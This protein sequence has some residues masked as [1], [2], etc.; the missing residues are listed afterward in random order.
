MPEPN[1][2][3]VNP[4]YLERVIDLTEVKDVEAAED[5]YSANGLKLVAKGTRMSAAMQE[6]LIVHKLKKPLEKCIKVV[7]GVD[8]DRIRSAVELV[9]DET[10]AIRTLIGPTGTPQQ[11]LTGTPL[12]DSVQLM[13]TLVDQTDQLSLQHYLKVSLI[14]YGLARQIGGDAVLQEIALT[15]GLMHDIGELYINPDYLQKNRLLRPVEWR[16][17]VAHP[18]IAQ[19]LLVDVSGMAPSV[20]RAVAEH[21]ERCDGLGYPKQLSA[22]AISP[23][24]KLLAVAEIL[25]GIFNKQGCLLQRAEI[26]LKIVPGEHPAEVVAAISRCRREVAQEPPTDQH[27]FE[28]GVAEVHDTLLRIVMAQQHIET[29]QDS[30]QTPPLLKTY[31]DPMLSRLNQ[32]QRAFS[33]TGMD[34]YR[35]DPGLAKEADNQAA[36]RFEMELVVNEIRWRLR[37]LSRGLSLRISDLGEAD[38][39]QCDSLFAS[40][41]GQNLN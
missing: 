21:H 38:Q 32:V 24:G 13:L 19:K 29:L 12:N 2:L 7:D 22:A 36:L 41:N 23:A 1:L 25:A 39:K 8:H 20:A 10:P 37:E 31:L 5:I 34:W 40:L 33:S 35:K 15:A 30:T 11:L 14:A 17:V 9:L 27:A 4:H 3:T 18:I 26:A 28:L 6:R 16:H